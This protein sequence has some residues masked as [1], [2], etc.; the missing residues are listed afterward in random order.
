[1]KLQ[2]DALKKKVVMVMMLL[3][4]NRILGKTLSI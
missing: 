2:L 4:N 3:Y 1:M